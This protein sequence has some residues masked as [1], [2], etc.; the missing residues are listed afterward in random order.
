[1]RRWFGPSREEVWREL[2]EQIGASYVDGGLWKGDKV[3]A[4]HGEWTI[5]LDTYTVHA[6]NT[7]AHFT[8][9]RAPYV[10]PGDF[11]FKIYRRGLFSDVGTFFGMQDVEV[12]HETFDRDFVIKGSSDAQLRELFS[13][14]RLRELLERQPGGKLEVK[15]DEGWFGPSFPDGVDELCFTVRG[16]VKDLER[17]RE[18]YDLFAESLDQLCRIGAAYDT[19]PGVQL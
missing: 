17:L 9:L 8:R 12:G 3:R 11:R 15:E 14:A 19:A 5:T 10:N 7:H 2:S 4:Q 13:S 18:M 1:M 16:V 6:N